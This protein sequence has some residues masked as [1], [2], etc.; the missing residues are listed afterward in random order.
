MTYSPQAHDVLYVG[1]LRYPPADFEAPQYASILQAFQTV[2][3]TQPTH[4]P[5]NKVGDREDWV[6]DG[7]RI[8]GGLAAY[9]HERLWVAL[10][11]TKARHIATGTVMDVRDVD[12]VTA[13][14]GVVHGV[15]RPFADEPDMQADRYYRTQTF[16]NHAGRKIELGHLNGAGGRD[17][18]TI[19]ADFFNAGHSSVF[20]KMTE[21]KMGLAKWERGQDVWELMGDS[22]VLIHQEGKPDAFLIQEFVALTFEYR[23][24]VVDHMLVSGAGRVIEHT[25]LDNQGT[26]FCTGVRELAS[27]VWDSVPGPVEFRLDLVDQYVALATK[28]VAD[29]Q[30]ECP[31]MLEYTLDVAMSPSGP[32]IVEL[33]GIRN[34]GLF[35]NNAVTIAAARAKVRAAQAHVFRPVELPHGLSAVKV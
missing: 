18:R 30:V 35:A 10:G 8:L 16:K 4:N 5:D 20:L 28:V 15:H 11:P 3:W 25:P 23:F 21:A 7:A 1:G 17:I 2:G 24:F 22:W 31:S 6:E 19:A 26:R 29:F 14:I 34:S 32:V 13:N 33:N 12:K 9:D 27:D